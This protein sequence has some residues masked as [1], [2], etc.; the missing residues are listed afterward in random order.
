LERSKVSHVIFWLLAVEFLAGSVWGVHR[1]LYALF[2]RDILLVTSFTQTGFVVSMF[3]LTKAVT[4]LGFGALSDRVGRKL[5]TIIGMILS[6]LGGAVIGLSTTYSHMLLGTA[7]I[8]LG[9]GSSFVGIMVSM[10]ESVPSGK[11]GLAMGLFELAAYG[12]SSFGSALGGYLAAAQGLRLP[13][14]MAAIISGAGAGAAFLM[15]PETRRRRNPAAEAASPE[16][17]GGYGTVFRCSIPLYIAGFSSKIMDS[18]VWSFL[19]LHLAALQMSIVEIAAVTSAFT[20]SWALSQPLA[21]HI[22]DRMGR[23]RIVVI[24]LASSAVAI[25]PY[26]LTRNFILMF[27]LALLLGFSA[28]LFYTPLVA[29]VGD[30][31]PP[32]L[33]GTLIGSYRF[34]RDMGYFVGPTLLGAVSDAYGLQHSFYITSLSLLVTTIIV[35]IFCGETRKPALQDTRSRVAT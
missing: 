14:H 3:G 10:N 9:G 35:G 1:G 17:A 11:R 2:T 13:F 20:F 25:L 33:E 24:G 32:N 28:A 12:G 18:L 4:N 31:A 8:G 26:V 16:G 6:G 27:I 15:V 21:G 5:T 19:P 7:L 29:M 30:L 23:K 22:S 34:F